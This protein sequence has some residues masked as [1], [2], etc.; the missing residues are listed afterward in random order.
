[1][2]LPQAVPSP[3]SD[4]LKKI[5]GERLRETLRCRGGRF[6][7]MSADDSEAIISLLLETAYPNPRCPVS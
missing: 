4:E 2:P 7:M 6:A 1:M 3:L 5:A